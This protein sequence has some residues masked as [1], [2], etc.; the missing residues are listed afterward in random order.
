MRIGLDGSFLR[1]PPSGTS[2]YIQGLRAGFNELHS[3]LDLCPLEP[4]WGEAFFGS[5]LTCTTK[6]ISSFTAVGKRERLQWEVLGVA[7]AA[8]KHGVDLLHIPHFSAPIHAG[9][10]LVVTIHDVIPLVLPEYRATAAMRTRL[11]IVRRTV[12]KAKLV[13]TPSQAAANDVRD[14]LGISEEKLRVTPEAAEKRYAP[15]ADLGTVKRNVETL[16]VGGPYI[17]NVGGL[18]VRK[19]LKVLIEAFAEVR[20][21]LQ[22]QTKLVIAGTAHS[23]NQTVFPP[24]EPVI[25]KLGLQD[26]VKLLGR[27]SE[28]DK[29]S[30]YQAADLYVTPSLY[31]GFGLTA[32][33]AMA[34]GI[35]TVAA[36]R[37]S[38]PEV[39]G[40][41][42]LLVE[43]TVSSVSQAIIDVLSN[44]NLARL[45]QTKGLL[46]ASQFTWRQTTELTI[47]A[48]REALAASSK[49]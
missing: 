40:N 7:R 41:G 43:P 44:E 12:Q 17:F 37:T 31:E 9:M 10:P 49:T 26:S 20:P 38:L 39:V 16:G 2:A 6:P 25:N 4:S 30:L 18:D 8:R 1:L 34:C 32:L 27:V 28:E 46:R 33:E 5:G 13:L 21:R 22:E 14:V 3:D 36:N 19:N 15:A 23:N 45:L 48:Y 42:G 47:D 24:L 35:P 11:A 29:L